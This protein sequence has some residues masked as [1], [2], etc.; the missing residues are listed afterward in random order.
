MMADDA[1]LTGTKIADEPVAVPWSTQFDLASRVSGRTYRIFVFQPPMP[2]PPAG[3]PVVTVLD[4]N[5]T[6]PIAAAMAATYAWSMCPAMVVG[7]GYPTENPVQMVA[8]R[9]RDLTPETSPEGLL[10]RPGVPTMTPD[11]VGGADAFHRFLTEELRPLVAARYAV[12]ADRQA[13]FGYSLAGLFTLH[14]LFSQ[15]TEWRSYAAASPSIWWDDRALLARECG[16]R[17]AVERQEA[18]PRVLISVGSREQQP[19]LR[20]APGM[21]A[22]EIEAQLLECRMV[23]NAWELAC[24][25]E[26]LKGGERYSASFHAFDEEDHLTGLAAS[27]GRAFDFALR[28]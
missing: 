26:R 5:L 11:H 24:R 7:V 17:R 13:L 27:V 20:V 14:A 10:Q 4:G 3:Y 2:A 9:V 18:S 6:F 19:P 21:T 12:D 23:D 15:P 22:D 1:T 16:F 28:D 8:S 25:L